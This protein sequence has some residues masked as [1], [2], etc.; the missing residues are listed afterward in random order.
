MS[1]FSWLKDWKVL[2]E[3]WD[4]IEPFVINLAEKMFPSILQNSMK[5]SQKQHSRLL[6]VWKN[7]KK[8]LKLH[9]TLWMIIV[10]IKVLTLLKH[11]QIT[12]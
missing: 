8:R 2:N 6:T 7:W 4:A 10:L 11:L 12:S 3:L 1:L 9:R 5:I